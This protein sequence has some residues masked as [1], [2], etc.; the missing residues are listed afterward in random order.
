MPD[1]TCGDSDPGG[2]GTAKWQSTGNPN[3]WTPLVS[4]ATVLRWYTD[5]CDWEFTIAHGP[6]GGTM[7][8]Y[9]LH[10]HL[11]ASPVGQYQK[12]S[13]YCDNAPSTLDVS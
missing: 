2:G 6:S 8:T 11:G 10:D 5:S 7:T 3:I 1:Y 13:G 12:Y 9:R 4:W